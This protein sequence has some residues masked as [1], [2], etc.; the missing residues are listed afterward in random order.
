MVERRS[1]K[2]LAAIICCVSL[3]AVGFVQAGSIVGWGTDASELQI[4][5]PEGEDFVAVAAGN[6]HS[7]V[8][9]S[10]GTVIGWGANDYG[11]IDVPDS[12]DIVAIAA[13]DEFSLFLKEDG[14]IDGCGSNQ[15]LQMSN[16]P[17]GNDFI[18]IAA[19]GRHA[20][21]LRENGMVEAWGLN[22]ARQ[23]NNPSGDDFIAIGAG[24]YHSSGIRS[25][26]DAGAITKWGSSGWGLGS[27]PAGEDYVAVDGGDFH[28]LALTSGGL[29]FAWGIQDG[30]NDDHGQVTDTPQDGGYVDIAAGNK[31][32]IALKDDG[33][34]VGWGKNIKGQA[35][36]PEGFNFI[37]IAAGKAHGLAIAQPPSVTVTSPNGGEVLRSDT[38][39]TITWETDGVVETV[40]IEYSVDNGAT[41]NAVSPANAGNTGSYEFLVPVAD[42][43]ECL[44]KVIPLDSLSGID[45][46][47]AVFSIYTCQLAGDVTGDCSVDMDDL[48]VIASEWTIVEE[49]SDDNCQLAGDVT[50]DCAV[51]LADLAVIASEWMMDAYPF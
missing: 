43:Q 23:S 1:F 17:A 32:N 11:Q 40:E 13:G 34:L 25:T 9:K 5:I 33:S 36:V 14:S 39:A 7:I 26:G 10:D 20:L 35:D 29:V 22:G 19:G 24:Y 30:S 3:C 15:N 12:N 28:G 51:D 45:E 31:F 37:A 16:I 8:L 21:A 6:L 38:I 50:G 42:S 27:I 41:W 4:Q 48:V 47:D 44:I 49:F 18:A 46:S 2:V